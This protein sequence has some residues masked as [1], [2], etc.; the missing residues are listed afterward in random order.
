MK[1]ALATEMRFDCMN[2]M[3]IIFRLKVK[4]FKSLSEIQMWCGQMVFE[5]N[6]NE[7]RMYLIAALVMTVCSIFS[8]WE[9][10]GF[11]QRTSFLLIF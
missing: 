4:G 1:N 3:D 5:C 8:Y 2:N 6:V 10:S 11:A 7:Q 9:K